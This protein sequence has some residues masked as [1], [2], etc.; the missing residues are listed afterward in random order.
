MNISNKLQT[1]ASRARERANAKLS[2]FTAADEAAETKRLYCLAFYLLSVV[3]TLAIFRHIFLDWSVFR[4]SVLRF[5][6]VQSCPTCCEEE[7]AIPFL[8]I[9]SL[10][11]FFGTFSKGEGDIRPETN[12]F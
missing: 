8:K 1:W 2:G 10:S 6:T 4:S 7:Y 3:G 11:I 12:N 9:Y 5:F